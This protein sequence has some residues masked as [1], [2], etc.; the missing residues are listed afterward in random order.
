MAFTINPAQGMLAQSHRARVLGDKA[1]SI[2]QGVGLSISP[3]NSRI[4]RADFLTG[5][6]LLLLGLGFFGAT[7]LFVMALITVTLA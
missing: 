6:T 4:P 1:P 3:E 5:L 7:T 2:P